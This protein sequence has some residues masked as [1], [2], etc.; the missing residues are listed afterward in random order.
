VTS[1][2]SLAMFAATCPVAG[3]T[4]A[5][6]AAARLGHHTPA[7]SPVRLATRRRMPRAGPEK[8]AGSF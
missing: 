1:A 6:P 2:D 8:A 7:A 4:G 5:A 3:G